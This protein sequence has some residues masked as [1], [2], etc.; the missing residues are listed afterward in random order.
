MRSIDSRRVIAIR[1]DAATYESATEQVLQWAGGGESRSV[2]AANVHV[3]MEAYDAEDYK[4]AVNNADLVVP[5]G[6]PLVWALRLQG[7]KASR[8]YG[9]DLTLHVCAAAAREG[10]AVGLYGSSPECLQSFREFLEDRF[11]GIDI[12]CAISPPFRQLTAEE[13]A[14]F[15]SRL[16]DS[17]ARIVLVGLGCPKQ[18]AWME[19]HRSAIPAVM[20]GVGAA[21]DFHT[22]RVRQA[23]RWM[24]KMGLEWA[25]RFAMEP[26]RLWARYVVH[27]PRYVVLMAWQLARGSWRRDG[28]GG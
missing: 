18:E 23:P 28:S 2:I 27:N 15:T 22:G 21:F 4:R 13:D 25:F 10:V 17:G 1:V 24:M 16:T 9:P 6:V 14:E 8:V 7:V 12:V 11:A 19:A 20:I 26:R 3:T 5:D